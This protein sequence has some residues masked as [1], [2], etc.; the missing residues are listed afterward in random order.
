MYHMDRC[1]ADAARTVTLNYFYKDNN[2]LYIFILGTKYGDYITEN[3]YLISW[4]EP[5]GVTS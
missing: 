5:F 3:I 2:Q 1:A 4:L